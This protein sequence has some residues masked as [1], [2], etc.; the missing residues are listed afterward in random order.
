MGSSLYDAAYSRG[1]SSYLADKVLP[2]LPHELSNGICSLNPGVE[3]LAISCVMNIDSNGNVTSYDIFESVIKSRKQMTYK[4]V[5]KIL[6]EN[7]TPEGYE[8]YKESLLLMQELAHILRKRKIKMGY[9][10][11]DIPEAKIIQD[12]TGKCI[13]IVKREQHEGEKLIEDFMIAANETI[14]THIYNMDLPFVY[15]VHG[16]PKPEKIEEFLNML[17]ILNIRVNTRGI[18]TSPRDM[19]K[20]LT[21]LKDYKEFPILSS[22][23]LR[24]MQKAIY[25][26]TNIGH[27]GL[28][29]KNYTHFTS[30]IRRFPDTTVHMLLR[31]Y[32]FKK[33]LDQDTIKYFS[34]YLIEVAD[35]SS[36]RE[37]AAVEA[38]RE[39]VDMKMAEYMESHIGEEYT[40]IITTVT[41]FGFFVELPNLVE[42]LVHISTLDGFYTYIPEM[43][44]LVSKDK[45]KSYRLGDEVK[46]KVVNAN[47]DDAMIDFEVQD[48]NS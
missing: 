6:E 4:C 3:R 37:Q 1:T 47:K 48:G 34:K 5:N 24:S 25:S 38:E 8:E 32:L 9:I 41:N 30:P 28:G 45:N 20:L 12:E 22:M 10:E 27:F 13:D 19:Q 15:R 18:A 44:A 14:A 43:L 46:I 42:G 23:L 39:V 40:G 16:E 33:E 31:T 36:E 26:P 29:L 11:F 17:K 35:H 7:I 21:E 2:M